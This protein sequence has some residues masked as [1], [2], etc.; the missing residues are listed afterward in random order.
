[1]DET[2]VESASS[3]SPLWKVMPWRS[4]TVMVCE[5]VCLFQERC[6]G[7]RTGLDLEQHGGHRPLRHV[8]VHPVM[9]SDALAQLDGDGMALPIHLPA[10]R[11][12]GMPLAVRLQLGQGLIAGPAVLD[13]VSLLIGVEE[14]SHG[15]GKGQDQVAAQGPDSAGSLAL[16]LLSKM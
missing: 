4:L 15:G 2:H 10:L 8:G 11:Q 16:S 13:Q 12:A 9:E 7:Q 5:G 6:G 1:M 14:L 3:V